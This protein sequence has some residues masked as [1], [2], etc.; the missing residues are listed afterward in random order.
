[1]KLKNFKLIINRI[2]TYLK[3]KSNNIDENS[4]IEKLEPKDNRLVCIITKV[5]SVSEIYD[6]IGESHFKIKVNFEC[7]GLKSWRYLYVD[8]EDKLNEIKEGYTFKF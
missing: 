7:R 4:N 5:I 2:L 3:L 1:M 8:S 6:G